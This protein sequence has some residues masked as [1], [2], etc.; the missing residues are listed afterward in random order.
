MKLLFVFY[1]PSGGVET[2]NR[3]RAVALQKSGVRCDFLY[4]SK[5]RNLLNHEG[6]HVFITNDDQE[7]KAILHKGK[8]DTVIITSDYRA[9]ERFRSLG[10]KGKIILE[11]Q[12]YGP[13]EVARAEMGKAIPFVQQYCD[14]LLYP[15][16]PHIGAIFREFFA[17]TPIFEFNNCFDHMAF[18]YQKLPKKDRPIIA[19]IGRL[20]DNKNWREF[21]HIGHHLRQKNPAID[22]YMFEDPSLSTPKERQD[23]IQLKGMLGL[24]D[25]VHLLQNLPN[26]QMPRY[27]SMI[28][29]SGGFLCSTSKVEGAPYSP[30]EAMS[31]RCPVLT[32]D[33][34]GVRSSIL[35]NQTGKYYQL[36][37]IQQAVVQ[38]EELMGNATLRKY[39]IENAL[40][41]LKSQFSHEQYAF[42]FNKMLKSI[43]V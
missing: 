32:T 3:Q 19:W 20:E 36:G 17:S 4:Y 43:G 25:S 40:L 8:Y 22:L 2:L 13:K 14:A 21:L 11:I 7:I 27:F 37:N 6:S 28:G 9:M 1:V 30:L 15:K 16:T 10:Y 38:A 5:R 23:F 39:I 41:H 29:D 26:S 42:H 35:H 33:S 24:D 34:D 12:G 31:C 18:T